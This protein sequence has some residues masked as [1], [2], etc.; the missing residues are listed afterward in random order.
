MNMLLTA[1]ALV[2]SALDP[3]HS[4]EHSPQLG[5]LSFETTCS[6][7]AQAA[8]ERGLGWLHSFEYR[9]AEDSFSEAA[10]ADPDCGIAD[11]GVAMSY[12]HP[13]WDGPTPAE[14][15][16]GKNA[17]GKAKAAGARSQRERDYVAALETFYRESDRLDLKTR[18]FAYSAA[19][20]QLHNRYPQDDEAAVFY[21]LSLITTG[22]MDG[23]PSFPRQKHAGAI[24]NQVLTKNPDHPGVAHYLIHSFDYP[25]L[26]ELALPAARRYAKIAP[27][28]AHAQHMPSHIFTR[29]GLW[30]EAITSNRAA[31]AAARAYAKSSGMPGAWDQ[32]L[33]AMDYLAYAYLQSARDAEAQQVLN[34]LKTISQAD[35][36]TRTVAYAVTAIPARVALER[37]HWREAASLELPANL[38]GLSALT[39]HKWAVAHIY[40]ARAVGAAR[41]GDAGSA[42]A[43]VAKLSALEQALVIRPGEYD[44]R[45]QVSIERQIAEAWAAHA[46]GKDDEAVRLMRA[47]ADLDDATEKNP[48]TPGSILPA[49][50]QLGE[51]L[52]D[53]GRPDEALK[54]Y[55]ASLQRAPRRLAGLYGAARSARLAGDTG[56]A[57][58]YFAELAK[59][60]ERGDAA[61]AEVKSARL[62]E[63]SLARTDN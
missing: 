42:H 33:H 19:M 3:E 31:E 11:W 43:E 24:L 39:V 32:Q 54:E 41:S 36:P 48:V 20:E 22:T 53:L 38:K 51:V 30:D 47:A 12:Y 52:L 13:L 6:P 14:Q 63:A 44:W 34:E 1:S 10:A 25:A 28:S 45:K 40:F 62:F 2:V 8:F 9:R 23:D 27:D 37:R 7:A 4:H 59:M 46:G 55:E 57:G 60:T 15:E 58:R 56:K 17:I 61:R 26:A 35:P 18:A 16:K 5:K 29:L 49:R 50:E 21:A